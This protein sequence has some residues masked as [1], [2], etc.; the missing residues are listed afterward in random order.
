[1]LLHGGRGVEGGERVVELLQ[2]AVTEAPVVQVV[3]QT[4]DQQPFALEEQGGT[5]T[6]S[7]KK[8]NEGLPHRPAH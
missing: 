5:Q 3:T 8:G 7:T 2:V 4:S 6:L 1:M